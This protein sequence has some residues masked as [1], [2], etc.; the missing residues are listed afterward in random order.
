MFCFEMVIHSFFVCLE[1]ERE[2]EKKIN[3]TSQ[4]EGNLIKPIANTVFNSTRLLLICVLI[5]IFYFNFL[6]GV[7]NLMLRT[8]FPIHGLLSFQYMASR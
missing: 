3:K 1:R 6:L 7:V 8:E 4:E 2:R 5:Y